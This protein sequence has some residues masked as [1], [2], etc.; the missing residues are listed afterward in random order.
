MNWHRYLSGLL[1]LLLVCCAGCA[2]TEMDVKLSSTANLNLNDA[3]EPLPVVVRIYQLTDAKPFE[4]A[5]F[6]ELWKSDLKVLGGVL[7][8][9][10]MV[11][12]DPASQKEVQIERHERTRYV[13]VMAAFRNI[14]GG[15]WRLVQPVSNSWL[16][17]RTATKLTVQM[18]GN[19]VK[20]VE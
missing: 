5:Q 16:S 10:D 15:H 9:K 8:R 3:D 1:M 19:R 13:A 18:S 4:E 11:V 2:S 6:D 12:L 14:K 17:T 20:L 7:L